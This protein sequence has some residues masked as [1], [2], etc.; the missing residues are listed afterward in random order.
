MRIVF[1]DRTPLDYT[2][3][4]PFERPFEWQGWLSDIVRRQAA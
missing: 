2:P 3:E 4:T 1:Y